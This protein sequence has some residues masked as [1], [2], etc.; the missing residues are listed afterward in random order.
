MAKYICTMTKNSEDQIWINLSDQSFLS[1]NFSN[2]EVTTILIPYRDFVHALPGFESTTRNLVD[3]LNM[4]FITTFDTMDNANN[5][6]QQL[7]PP[8][9]PDSIQDKLQKLMIEKRN[10]LN[11]NYTITNRVEA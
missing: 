8:F 1:N 11:V 5:A 10:D 7:V 9:T 6:M 2:T 3:S 4:E